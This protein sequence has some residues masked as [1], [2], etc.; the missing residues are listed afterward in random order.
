LRGIEFTDLSASVDALEVFR[1]FLE[2][3]QNDVQRLRWAIIAGHQAAQAFMISTLAGSDGTGVLTRQDRGKKGEAIKRYKEALWSGQYP[4]PICP[5]NALASFM[6]LYEFLQD[7]SDGSPMRRYVDSH[8]FR[9]KPRDLERVKRLN[10]LRNGLIHFEPGG[11]LIESG[12]AVEAL[13]GAYIV[14]AFTIE[15]CELITWYP[16]NREASISVLCSARDSLDAL[17][18]MHH[19]AR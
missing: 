11:W 3:A 7:D 8:G 14:L 13:I 12:Y 10:E 18:T 6:E 4:P 5:K 15:D 1:D 19:V 2:A 17:C 9:P 16:Q